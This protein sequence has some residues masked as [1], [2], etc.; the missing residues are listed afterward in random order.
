M[1]GVKSRMKEKFVDITD[2]FVAV[3]FLINKLS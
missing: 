3:F 1:Q 2:K